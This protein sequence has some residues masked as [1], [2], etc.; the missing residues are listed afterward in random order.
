[1]FENSLR[2]GSVNAAIVE[3]RGLGII[4]VAR[5]EKVHCRLLVLYI[6]T[7]ELGCRIRWATPGLLE[8]QILPYDFLK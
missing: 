5:L 7:T 8:D 3:S 1:M 4:C 2:V 6:L